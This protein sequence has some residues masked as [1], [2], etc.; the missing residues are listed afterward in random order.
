MLFW[1][2][3]V[4]HNTVSMFQTSDAQGPFRRFIILATCT[5]YQQLLL[6]TGPSAIVADALNLKDLL[7]DSDICPP[8]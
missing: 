3:W 2:G 6:E 4:A 8:S 1:L 7:A 5:T